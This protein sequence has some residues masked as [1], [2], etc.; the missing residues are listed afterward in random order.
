MTNMRLAIPALLL[1]LLLGCSGS[2]QS[3]RSTDASGPT[4]SAGAAGQP[5]SQR[6]ERVRRIIADQ[7]GVAP[8][9]VVDSASLLDLGADSLDVIELILHLEKEFALEI[10]DEDAERLL[11]VGD[12]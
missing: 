5:Q 1:P 11:T 12:V 3:N 6:A 2:D 9:R 7:L 4:D 10:T 8:D